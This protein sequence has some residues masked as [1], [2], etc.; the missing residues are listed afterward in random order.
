MAPKE[1]SPPP[2]RLTLA[3]GV[4]FG[5]HAHGE[6]TCQDVEG[7]YA[8]EHTGNFLGVGASLELRG[9]LYKPL[10]LHVRALGVGNVRKLGVHSGLLG[11][12]VGLGA[13]S[14]YAFVRGE[15]MLLPTLGSDRYTPPFYDKP[16]ARDVWWAHMGMVSVGV[17]KPVSPR[18]ALE[19]WGGVVIGPR[20]KRVSVTDEARQDRVIVS[21]MVSLGFAY[22]VLMARGYVPPPRQPRQRRQF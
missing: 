18:A 2:P 17:R 16:A 4:V 3:G 5:P 22:D 20:A 7:G 6:A 19:L 9:Q 21:F 10:Y 13:Y 11:G 15:Y 8:C 1:I 12:G 14:R